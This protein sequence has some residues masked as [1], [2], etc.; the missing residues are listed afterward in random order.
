[1]SV[2]ID[3][4]FGPIRVIAVNEVML[5]RDFGHAG[6]LIYSISI[7]VLGLKRPL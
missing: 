5:Q 3:W 1:M 6:P 4:G 2:S 7:G